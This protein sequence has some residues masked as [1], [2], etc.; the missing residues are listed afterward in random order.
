[1][2]NPLS[3]CGERVVERSK[4]RVSQPALGIKA[5][6]GPWLKPVQ[7]ERRARPQATPIL[8]YS[9]PSLA[10][11][12]SFCRTGSFKMMMLFPVTDIRFS[13]MKS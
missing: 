7:Y 2:Q 4:D 12:T 3:A 8:N 6:T 13:W 1:M 9:N 5:D 10:S 11:L